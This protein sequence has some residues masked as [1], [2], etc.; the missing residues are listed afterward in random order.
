MSDEKRLT[1]SLN[2]VL[3]VL[4]T[5]L[6]ERWD[7]I[8]GTALG[9]VGVVLSGMAFWEAK[10]AKRAA[11]DAGRTVK[12]QTVTI[13][14][15]EISQ[16][17]DR[18]QPGIKY[19]DA[20]DLLAELNRRIR[21][22][23]AQFSNDEM[24]RNAVTTLLAA[25]TQAHESLQQVRPTAAASESEAPDAVYYGIESQFTAVNNGIADVL[26]QLERRVQ[27]PGDDNGQS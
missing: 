19:H 13:D 20:R 26:G 27:R 7:F 24:L 10:K 11:I 23:A 17:L 3:D 6:W 2:F 25:L 12:L 5:P 15:T 22:A 9:V 8:I 21:R 14:L 16:K 18:V 1:E 4:Q